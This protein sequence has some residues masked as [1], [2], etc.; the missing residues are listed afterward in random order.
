MTPA[1]LCAH[2]RSPV[3][4]RAGD[5][6]TL[7]ELAVT[8][9]IIAILA[10]VAMPLFET[11]AR[12]SKEQDLREALRQIRTAIDAY[13]QAYDDKKIP[14]IVGATGYP[15]NLDIL[16][17]GIDD[18]TSPNKRK[19]YFLRRVP[20]DPFNPDATVSAADSWAKRS[21]ASPPDEPEEGDD[22]YDVFTKSKDKDMRGIP[23]R[24]W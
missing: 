21:Y 22:V 14:Q 7:V 19:I 2:R 13:K 6:F 20:R 15:P 3:R 12:R 11:A 17:K 24:D 23:Y 8:L 9:A 18:P 5:G 16:V 4:Q 1:R 10:S